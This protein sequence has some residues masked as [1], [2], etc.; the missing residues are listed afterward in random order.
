M[1]EGFDIGEFLNNEGSA[2][3]YKCIYIRMEG[4]VILALDYALSRGE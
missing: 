3:Y 4:K 2:I 1:R